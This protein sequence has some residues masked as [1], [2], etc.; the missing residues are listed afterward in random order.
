MEPHT[1]EPLN[2][3]TRAR[4]RK[5]SLSRKGV[6][7]SGVGAAAL[8]IVMLL[9]G[10]LSL[11][12]LD[13][14]PIDKLTTGEAVIALRLGGAEASAALPGGTGDNWIVLLDFQGRGQA[15]HVER[16]ERG[17]I[18]WTELGVSYGVQAEDFLTTQ[19]GTQRIPR[20][21]DRSVEYFRFALPDGRIEVISA[22][23]GSGIRADIIERDGT[24][25]SVET[26]DKSGGFG[27]CGSRVLAIM[28]TEVSQS[29]K[30]AAFEVYAAQSGGEGS[31]PEDFSVVVQ[32]DDPAGATPRILAAAPMIPGLRSVQHLYACEG[33]LLTAPSIQ[34]DDP[35]GA[36][37]SSVVAARGTLVL[38]RWDLSTG[39]RSVSPVLDEAGNAIHLNEDLDIYGDKAILVGD[40]YRLI[41]RHGHAFSIN[42]TSGQGRHLFSIPEQVGQGDMVFQVT[43]SG[44][45][46]LTDSSREHAVTLSYHPWDGD[47]S[48]VVLSTGSLEGYLRVRKLFSGGQRAIESFALRP[49][50]D[51]GAQ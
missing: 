27:L 40:E 18:A 15:G 1:D 3:G 30:S 51:G 34:V 10:C 12:S 4:N 23:R 8:S 48:R 41:S 36:R 6:R 22:A 17:D 43:E 38:Q 32:L 2:N 26:D 29:M 13:E 44:V 7:R 11:A 42:L 33:N 50:W 19:E 25:T 20:V 9:S 16:G 5:G 45:Y 31:E 49:G 24:M 35:I 46:F 39:Q 21:G 47:D 28:N 37:G 14:K